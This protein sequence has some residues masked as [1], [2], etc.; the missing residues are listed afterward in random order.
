MAVFNELPLEENTSNYI[1]VSHT[2]LVKAV[3]LSVG[4]REQHLSTALELVGKNGFEV[5][6]KR[7]DMFYFAM[8][9][10]VYYFI[11]IK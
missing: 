2:D 3:I 5:G 9:T 6:I 11:I 10:K 7:V 8:E 4:V 1:A